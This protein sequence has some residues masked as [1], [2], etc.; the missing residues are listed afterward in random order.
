LYDANIRELFL[1]SFG[2]MAM[3]VKGS[4]KAAKRQR[5]GKRQ[6]AKVGAKG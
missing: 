1:K 6:K 3:G 4:E 5:K 2:D